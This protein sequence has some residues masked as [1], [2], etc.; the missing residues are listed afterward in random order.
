MNQIFLSVSNIDFNKNIK[1]EEAYIIGTIKIQCRVLLDKAVRFKRVVPE[2][3]VNEF[4]SEDSDNSII[5]NLPENKKEEQLEHLETEEFFNHI[6]IF[7]TQ[8]NLN[9]VQL[10]NFLIDEKSRHEIVEEINLN[11]NTLDTHIRRLRIKFSKF[12]KKS[13][14]TDKILKKYDKG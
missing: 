7:K 14:Y 10:L 9:E 5:N 3:F 8:L 13:G 11:L 2:S 4:N 12:L 6:N 1:N